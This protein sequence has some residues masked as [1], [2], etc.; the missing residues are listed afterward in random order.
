MDEFIDV[1]SGDGAGAM[2]DTFANG[3]EAFNGAVGGEGGMAGGGDAFMD[4]VSTALDGGAVPGF[5]G[6]DF[7]DVA[8]AFMDGLEIPDGATISDLPGIMM[9][10]AEG[11]MPDG[12]E[13]PEGM[14]DAMGDM[15]S[16]MSDAMGDAQAS[17]IA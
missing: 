3:A 5:E 4:S 17:E 14:A 13:M 6:G 9:D 1:M 2:M 10:A 8:D 11:M 7:G 15:F 12:F 16:S